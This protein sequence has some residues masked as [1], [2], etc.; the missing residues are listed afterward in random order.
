MTVRS[1]RLDLLMSDGSGSHCRMTS[2]SPRKFNIFTAHIVANVSVEAFHFYSCGHAVPKCSHIRAQ[3]FQSICGRNVFQHEIV[4][5]Y[6][7]EFAVFDDALCSFVWLRLCFAFDAMMC[8][9]VEMGCEGADVS[10]F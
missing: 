8:A 3:L 4:T 6:N 2:E 7:W 1:D 10:F 9:M 5:L